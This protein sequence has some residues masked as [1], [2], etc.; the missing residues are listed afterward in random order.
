MIKSFA[1][2]LIT[3]SV[4]AGSAAAIDTLLSGNGTADVYVNGFLVA[5]LALPVTS[6]MAAG[7]AALVRRREKDA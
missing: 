1:Q 2:F 6:L 3:L 5:G 7:L 4:I